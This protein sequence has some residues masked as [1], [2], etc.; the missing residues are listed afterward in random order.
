MAV[1]GKDRLPRVDHKG[2]HALCVS[3]DGVGGSSADIICFP[4]GVGFIVGVK[5]SRGPAGSDPVGVIGLWPLDRLAGTGAS[6][7]P[8]QVVQEVLGSLGTWLKTRGEA[9]GEVNRDTVGEMMGETAGEMARDSRGEA[10]RETPGQT[11]T[12]GDNDGMASDAV[13]ADVGA[14]LDTLGE[15]VQ[16]AMAGDKA[17]KEASGETIGRGGDLG[18]S[19]GNTG[20]IQI[21][22]K[23]ASVSSVGGYIGEDDNCGL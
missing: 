6:S 10:I 5:V 23:L 11:G 3:Q 7:D 22:A 2:Q 21:L 15:E 8:I 9:A 20:D 1:P 12:A 19:L 14:V 13:K 18:D 16:G 4:I 17:V